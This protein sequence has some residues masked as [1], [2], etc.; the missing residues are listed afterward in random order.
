MNEYIGK[1]LGTYQ[2]LEQIGQG[3]MA[4]I[5]KAY[6]PSMDRY[7]AIKVLASHFTKD[8]TFVARFTQ[9]ARTLAGLEH[10]HILPVHD[11]GEQEGT[12]YLVMRYIDAGTLKDLIV[13]RGP[14]ELS[15]TARIL[16]QVGR[17]LGY[18]HSQGIVHR[19]IK[20]T[21]VLVDEQGNA[22]LTD[23][24]IAK[25][26]AGTAQFTATGAIVG[27]PAYMAPEQGIGKPL[28]HRCDIY[29]LGVMLY[30]MTTGQVPYEAET[31]LAV[32]LQHVNAPL[33]PP[34][35]IDPDLPEPVERV[36]LK[37]LAKAP[38]DRFQTT[39]EMVETLQRAVAGIPVDIAPPLPAGGPTTVLPQP[40]DEPALEAP[41][42][43]PARKPIPWLP[44]AGGVAVLVALLIAALLVL[45]R[46]GGSKVEATPVPEM[47]PTELP[48]TVVVQ[49]TEPP[50][51]APTLPP[52]TIVTPTTQQPAA[53]HTVGWTH[54]TNGNFV[55]ALARQDDYL[56]AGGAGGLV[57]WNLNDGSYVKLGI[58][59][60]L[61]SSRVN[62][63]LVD[64]DGNLW[65]A[66]EAGLNR[67]DGQTWITFD[68]ADGLDSDNVQTLFLDDDSM[69]WAG[70]AYG[71]R[72][73]NYYDG[74]AWGPPSIPPIPV[75]F[76]KPRAFALDGEGGLFVGLLE[77]GLAYFD[78]D[79]WQVF[80][81]E[82]GLPSDYVDDLLLLDDEE[83]LVS[84]D[85]N[86]VRFDLETGEW[87]TIPQLSDVGLYD[88]RMH[89][90]QDGSL[91]FAGDGGVI[92]YDPGAGDWQQFESGLR[93]V[94]EERV[95]R[96]V[97]D[98]RGLWMGTDGG[99]VALYDGAGW[100][101][102]V[103]DAPLGGNDAWAIQRD[104]S[105]TLW[106]VHGDGNG[107]S[108]YDPTNDT[109]QTFG[110]D[111]GALDWPSVPGVDGE[112]NLWIGGYGEI[113]QY[114]GQAW[115]SFEPDQLTDETVFGIVFGPD[116]V[117]WLW[118]YTGLIRH[119]PATDE[120]TVFTADDHPALEGVSTVYVTRDGVVWVGSDYGLARYDG[121]DW[122]VSG[123]AGDASPV[124]AEEADVG[125]I[126]QAPDGSLWVV[127]VGDLYHLDDGQWSRFSWPDGW[128]GT[129]AIGPDG[130]V[131][132]GSEGLGRFDPSG[133]GWQPPAPDDGLIERRVR[134]IH[135]TP[136][137]VVWI[138][139]EGGVSRYVPGE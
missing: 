108:R 2:I 100:Q 45:P 115:R 4:T 109:W 50:A 68:T 127:A 53:T 9:E 125:K 39:E 67:F 27:T 58:A 62:D 79:E 48:E 113:I 28:D 117:Q 49:A 95:T 132:V 33:P 128:I 21:N 101:P 11:Y 92:R 124:G 59:D 6:Q 77:K 52:T 116:D 96:I 32:L 34:R 137:G 20:P 72:G 112:G 120:W 70:T 63:L 90:A 12:T 131:W 8:A 135:V 5:F 104:G 17:A 75:E 55:R 22:F 129:M 97:E 7:V 26:M 42:V 41:V 82:D 65:V 64:R 136:D 23:F 111:E 19:D 66:T 78:G 94:P 81:R 110:D 106:F 139:T 73:L 130:T 118:T 71:E 85:R 134:A 102:W 84:F 56:W 35:Q 121:S 18:A 15:E 69:L 46:L 89:Q 133:G 29:A 16:G 47:I 40:A 60:G 57:H 91:W 24:G 123:A 88:I 36:I 83:L 103:T 44:I 126:T 61:A 37:A 98:E 76:P 10:P 74:I 87:E 119:D 25:L 14:L 31:P 86:V 99:G 30:E 1:T 54:Y 80:T 3:G 51:A 114:D 138:G 122:S 38:D 13:Q 105:G 43:P 93:A 107:L